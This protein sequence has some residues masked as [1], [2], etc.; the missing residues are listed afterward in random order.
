MNDSEIIELD[1]STDAIMRT[2][3]VRMAMGKCKCRVRQA[4]LWI[5]TSDL[6]TTAA[7]PFYSRR[8]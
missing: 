8:N 2:M 3:V 6:P 1:R 4:T 5:A 7:Y